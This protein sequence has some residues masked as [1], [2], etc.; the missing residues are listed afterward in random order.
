MRLPLKRSFKCSPGLLIGEYS[1]G[2]Q[3][4]LGT[5]SPGAPASRGPDLSRRAETSMIQRTESV[6]TLSQEISYAI[7]C[8]DG[9]SCYTQCPGSDL[10]LD[11]RLGANW[12]IMAQPVADKEKAAQKHA[13]GSILV[14]EDEADLADMLCFNLEREGYECRTTSSGDLA[15]EMIRKEQPDLLLLDRM[16]P[17]IPGDEVVA[18]LKR[19]P[20]TA[21]IPVILVTAK[22][23]ETDELVGFA[24]GADD[25]IA[26]PFSMKL[27]LA[28]IGAV[29]RRSEAADSDAD[30]LALGPVRLVPSRYEVTVNDE[31][32]PLTTTEFKLLKT[33]MNAR[34]R[35]L[36]RSQLLDAVLGSEVI[37][38]DR[39]IDVHVTALRKKLG[40]AGRWIQT[41]RGVGYT[42]RQP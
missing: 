23:E 41:V 36:S 33:L 42:F 32:V 9:G 28:R 8:L 39:T 37:V 27:L 5:S 40:E 12:D 10:G 7:A 16:L 30:V 3:I 4:P 19:D 6:C 14:V 25:Y 15:L 17:G 11:Y 18:Q 20:A 22:T 1:A 38:T 21:S 26:K 31:N 34:G 35:V 13:R 24:L 2:T 29:L